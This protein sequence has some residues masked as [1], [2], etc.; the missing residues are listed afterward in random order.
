MTFIPHTDEDRNAMLAAIGVERLEAL[1]EDIPESL[2]FPALG[3]PPG[4]SELEVERELQTIAGESARLVEH[5]GFLGAGTYQHFIPAT[6]DDILRRGE[7]FTSY[8]PYQPEIAQ[9]FL[10]AT[11]EYQSMICE[12]MGMDVSTASHYD[13]AT[14][15]AEA[16]L[17]ALS[18]GGGRRTKIIVSRQL[19]PQYREVVATYLRGTT[20][21]LVVPRLAEGSANADAIDEEM[22]RLID[23]DAAACVVQSPNYFGQFEPV[24]E[25]AEKAH[26]VGAL[27]I[28]VPDPVALGIF[29]APGADGA[30][31][32]AAE[33][34]A[35]GIAPSFGGPHLGILAT[36][37]ALM[38]RTAG[39]LVG[40]TSD[41]AGER[42]YVLT[43]ATREQH[44]RREKATSNICTNAALMALA[45]AVHLATLGRSGLRRVAELCY[46]KAHY[47]AAQIAALPNCRI[48]PQ[49]PDRPFFKEFIVDLPIPAERASRAIEAE[50][51]VLGGR[52]LGLDFPDRE[53]Q[54]LLAVTELHTRA[55]IDALVAVLRKT[56]TSKVASP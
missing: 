43:L 54:L 6:V 1:F 36:K 45:A 47:A 15:L 31:I 40:E 48:N 8:T 39:R 56:V 17:L 14:A 5:P 7:F 33:G 13:G 21:E 30:D 34:Q 37:Q 11:F 41:A 19:H 42:G 26:A 52:P 55:D 25:L 18:A 20:A 49:A 23:E 32:V 51:G 12:L 10:Q 38:R 44:I 53:D 28:A 4:R 3:L 24:A 27:L 22:T 46:H 16:V 29:R 9:G 50:L 35:L 2:R